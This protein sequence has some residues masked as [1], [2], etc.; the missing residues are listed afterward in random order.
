MSPVEL[1]KGCG[2]IFPF[3]ARGVCADCLGRIEEQ[4]ELVREHLRE[5]PGARVAEIAAATGVPEADIAGFIRAGRLSW[6]Q[7]GAEEAVTCEICGAAIGAGRHCAPCRAKLLQGLKDHGADE[8]APA[9][10]PAPVRTG[11][12]MYSGRDR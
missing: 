12:R 8:P 1:C 9:R 6:G 10:P 3:L 5:N 2:R 4:F 7:V 11:S